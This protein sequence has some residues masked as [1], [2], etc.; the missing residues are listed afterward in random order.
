VPLYPELRRPRYRALVGDLV[1]ITLLVIFA[2]AGFKVHGAVDKLAVLGEGVQASGGVVQDGF[3]SAADAVDGTPVVGDELADGLRSA[4]EGSGGEVVELGEQGEEGAHD[5]ANVLGFV[6]FALPALIVLVIWLPGR[7]SQVKRLRAASQVLRDGDTEERRRLLAM[8]AAFSLPYGQL[9]AY[10][11]DPLGDLED[12]R[13]DALVAA[14]MEDA[15]LRPPPAEPP[16]AST[17]VG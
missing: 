9:L 16:A 3:D 7:V 5:L 13:Y 12:G 17:S 11:R 10:T 15:G 6:T 8:R 4:G 14:A 2:W 1:A